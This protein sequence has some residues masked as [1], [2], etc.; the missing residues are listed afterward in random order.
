MSHP[1]A[2]QL[3]R[4]LAEE[5][6]LME[7][8][9]V[10][11]HVNA[12]ADCLEHLEQMQRAQPVD[13]QLL[14]DLLVHPPSEVNGHAR[15]DGNP[16]PAIAVRHAETPAAGPTIPGYDLLARV[17]AG[18]M[19]EVYKARQRCTNRLVALKTL[20]VGDPQT[21][22]YRQRLDRFRTEAEA[23][24]RLQHPHIVALYEVGEHAGGPYFTMEWVPGCNLADKLAGT[25]L[26]ERQAAEWTALLADAVQHAHE[27]G[28]VH[29]DLKP[30]NILLRKAITDCTDDTAKGDQEGCAVREENGHSRFAHSCNPCD[31]WF[32]AV[33]KISDFGL[34][35]L[36]DRNAPLT[37]PGQWLGT[38]EYMAPEQT[39]D[40]AE[41]RN[42]GPAVD[43]YALGV[44]LYEMLT[45][46]PPFKAHE[47]LETLRQVRDEEPV[48]PRRLRPKLER[49][50]ETIC[51]KCLHKD[52]ARRYVSARELATDLRRW[53]KGEPISARP[54][55]VVERLFKWGRRHPERAGLAALALA[56]V[57]GLA[58]SSLWQLW[59][60]NARYTRQL[61]H[62][63]EHQ[64]LLVKYAVGQTAKE[65]TLAESVAGPGPDRLALRQF[66]EQ[67]RQAFLTWFTRPGEAPPII[68]WFIMDPEGLILADSYQDPR[69]VGRPY[70]FRDYYAG[71][72]R[73]EA[74]ADRAAV[75]ISRVYE[76]EQDGRFK[77][78]VITRIWQNDRILGLLGASIA[79]GSKMVALDM[80][81]ELPGA[82]LV[83]PMDQAVRPGAPAGDLPKYVV[84]L[85]GDYAVEGQNPLAIPPEQAEVLDQFAQT[86]SLLEIAE[87]LTPEGR[88]VNYARVGDSPF[89][90]L[91]AQPCPWPLSVLGRLPLGWGLALIA[92]GGGLAALW[93][94]R[95]MQR[96]AR[97]HL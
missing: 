44:L 3:R 40:P 66:L 5:L 59:A 27:H 19:G 92:G 87:K 80:S 31:P 8:D 46:R 72:L 97:A 62:S 54:S 50:L 61:A 36:F 68:N 28:V 1:S 77:F 30:A 10:E 85:H 76:S 78:T 69:S 95:R 65:K 18:G 89:V 53:L 29:R 51:L 82:R 63:T 39:A 81:Q 6:D 57:L 17:G 2:A 45:G 4:L 71:L 84:V 70:P 49:D 16:D 22:E 47:P 35:K 20:P 15:C 56:L 86:P 74:L 79:V 58:G 33:P 88:Y 60:A 13:W 7:R 43:V 26:P 32:S 41:A 94:S 34:A 73:Q 75:Y 9:Q 42:S 93:R 96:A 67:T 25:P 64:L 21:S 38:P 48:S 90:V 83:G 12:C 14:A 24:G 11:S 91:V 23:V 55:G 52:P 37:A